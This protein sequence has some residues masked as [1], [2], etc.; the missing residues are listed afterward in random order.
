MIKITIENIKFS[1]C[2]R[3]DVAFDTMN[4]LGKIRFQDNKHLCAYVIGEAIT[5]NKKVTFLQILN[6]VFNDC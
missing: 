4:E 3:L 2:R 5:R 1:S 6:K